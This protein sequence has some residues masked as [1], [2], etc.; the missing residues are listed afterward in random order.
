MRLIRAILV[1]EIGLAVFGLGM[2][3]ITIFAFELHIDHNQVL[4]PKRIALAIVGGVSLLSAICLAVSPL[5]HRLFRTSIMRKVIRFVL[6]LAIPFRW[7]LHPDDKAQEEQEPIHFSR[8]S[9]WFAT[10]GAG[11]VILISLWFITS[12]KWVSWEPYTRYFNLQADAFLSGQLPLLEKP[13]ADLLALSNPY[14]SE[15][16]SGINNYIWD[17][18][19]YRGKYYLYWGPIPALL[20]TLAKIVHPGVVEDQYLLLF[21]IAGLAVAQAALLHFL[22]KTCFPRI[23]DWIVALMILVGGLNTPVFWLVNRPSVYETAIA[24]GQF[25]LI[26]GLFAVLRGIT[27]GKPSNLWLAIAGLSWGAAIGCR[28]NNVLAIGWMTGLVCL[29]LFFRTKPRREWF[30]QILSLI[31]PIL[32]CG[33]GLAWYNYARFE[34]ILEFGHRYQLTGGALPD[35]YSKVISF[36]YILPNLYNILARPLVFEWTEFPFVFSPFIRDNMWPKLIFYPRDPNYY[37]AEPIA[38]IFCSIPASWLLLFPILRPIQAARNWLNERSTIVPRQPSPIANWVSWMV[39][40]ALMCNLGTILMFIS[41]TMRYE[42]DIAPLLIVLIFICIDWAS[43]FFSSHP[44]LQRLV[45]ILAGVLC[46]VSI[47]IGL[48]VNFQNGDYRFKNNNPELYQAI[49]H[50][51]TG[52]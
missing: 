40:G 20:A 51:L 17:A 8:R 30:G 46:V 49:S 26:S 50:F 35:D 2:V 10:A 5:L 14:Q 32:L 37:F 28:T 24:G 18:S 6:W 34:N 21:F 48:F 45:L 19:L 13:P 29:F 33:V 12:G 47:L 11:I 16:R 15:N 3:F 36:S 44:R 42:A 1:T 41:N 31:I 43:T 4:G 7:F 25:F 22:H 23:S 52:E 9:G 27:I 39:I 38:G